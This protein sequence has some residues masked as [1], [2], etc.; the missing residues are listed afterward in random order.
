M[1]VDVLK[2]FMDVKWLIEN[3][4]NENIIILD[5]RASLS[6][7]LDGLKSFNNCHIKGAS[8]VSLEDVS[9]GDI[10]VHGGRHPLPDLDKF[11]SAMQKLG[12]NNCSKIVI[13]DDGSLAMAARL[14]WL[15]KYIGK[16][17]VYI[18]EGGIKK[19]ISSGGEVTDERVLIET[20]G[21]LS[22]K[23]QDKMI[24]DMMYVKSKI[25]D[26]DT[27]IVDAREHKRYIGEFEPID[28]IAGHIPN[29]LNYPWT[30][31]VE[32]GKVIT[33]AN[34]IDKFKN[35][36]DYNEIIVHCGSGITA[37]VTIIMLDEI[38]LK[39]TL[40]AGGYSD[41]ISYIENEIV[42]EVK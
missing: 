15:L 38:G 24:V 26:K 29:T 39:A 28:P 17:D 3:I 23:V 21:D 12:I 4:D 19:Y 42:K 10:G 18:L 31:I 34:A 9:T 40:Y 7:P 16:D 1:E 37:I 25:N 32:D 30:E 5:A 35:L 36:K 14:W 2:H 27:A 6:D 41:W 13:Y 33:L 20:Q 8:F 11:V 22:L